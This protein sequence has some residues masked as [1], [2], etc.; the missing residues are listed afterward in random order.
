MSSS[1]HSFRELVLLAHEGKLKL[2]A[3]QRKWAWKTEK[4]LK[5]YDSLR[6]QYPIGALLFLKGKNDALGPRSFNGS[7]EDAQAADTLSLVLDGQQRLTA[8]IHLFHGTG[9]KQYF[10]DLNAIYNHVNELKLDLKDKGA[11]AAFLRGLDEGDGYI[12]ARKRVL[13]PRKLLVD[14]HL[15]CTSLLSD[16]AEL[17]IHLSQYQAAYSDRSEFVLRLIQPHFL[18]IKTDSV[19]VIEVDGDTQ[20]ESISRIFTTLNT[21]GQLLT[22]FELVVSILFPH[23]IDLLDQVRTL[24]EVGRF[25]PQMDKSGEV[26]LQTIAILAGRDPKKSRLPNTITAEIYNEYK[27]RAFDAL[28]AL[29]EHLTTYLGAGLNVPRADLVPYDA[30]YAPMAVALHRINQSEP[31]PVAMGKIRKQLGQWFVGAALSQRYQEGVHNKQVRDLNEFMA[32]V[33][34]EGR[35]PDWI[36][37]VN[38]PSLRSAAPE[39]AIGKLLRALIN[40]EVPSD[41]LYGHQIGFHPSATPT[42]KHHIFPTKYVPNLAGSTA[43]NNAD[44]AL[45]IMFLHS[46]TNKKWINNNPADHVAEAELSMGNVASR[47]LKQFISADALAVLKKPSKTYS[48]FEHFILLREVTFQSYIAGEFGFPVANTGTLADDDD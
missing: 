13:D 18:L 42:E 25:Y 11:V 8:G 14:K 33:E 40:R 20:L 22:P 16:A 21:T 48:D 26:L 9:E 47:Y 39:G 34:D 38:I 2:P 27:E 32:W 10:L 44:K 28:E 46:D 6:Q 37:E 4:V 29:G 17:G 30:I 36:S 12:L 35:M 15:L 5:L 43:K 1:S 41:P 31:S 45:N 23:D 24:R 3:F 7:V 19:P